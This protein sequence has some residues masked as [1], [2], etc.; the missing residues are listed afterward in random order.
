MKYFFLALL[1]AVSV[2]FGDIPGTTPIGAPIAPFAT[3]ANLGSHTPRYGYGGTLTGGALAQA[4]DLNWYPAVRRHPGQLFCDTNNLVV[5]QLA[6]DLATWQVLETALVFTNVSSL[7]AFDPSRTKPNTT[8]VTLGRNAAGD[9][10]AAGYYY[11]A[12]SAVTTNRGTAFACAAAGR[13]LWNQVGLANIRM[14]GAVNSASTDNYA[15]IQDSIDVLNYAY[16]GT[17]NFGIATAPVLAGSDRIIGD[18]FRFSVLTMLTRNMPA[19]IA[20]G[21]A[22]TIQGIRVRQA[23][24]ATTAETNSFGLNLGTSFRFSYVKDFYVDGFYNNINTTNTSNFGWFQNNFTDVSLLDFANSAAVLGGSGGGTQNVLENWYIKGNTANQT[25]TVTSASNVGTEIT[26]DFTGPSDIE[27]GQYVVLSGVTPSGYNAGFFV[28][29][30][31][32]TTITGTLNSDPGSYVSGGTLTTYWTGADK[33][34]SVVDIRFIDYRC[35]VMNIEWVKAPHAFTHLNTKGDIFGL[36]MEGMVVTDASDPY[37]IGDRFRPSSIK[38]WEYHN[39]FVRP[40]VNQYV[41]KTSSAFPTEPM[42]MD[43]AIG[44]FRDLYIPTNSTLALASLGS[45]LNHS[46]TTDNNRIVTTLRAGAIPVIT[47]SLNSQILRAWGESNNVPPPFRT[48]NLDSVVQSR[49]L[50][51]GISLSEFPG[52]TD[53]YVVSTMGTPDLDTNYFT[54][55]V[56]VDVP[57]Q[58]PALAQAGQSIGIWTLGSSATGLH[59]AIAN[60]WNLTLLSSGSLQLAYRDSSVTSISGSYANFLDRFGGRRVTITAVRGPDSTVLYAD[61]SDLGISGAIATLPSTNQV[62][63]TYFVLGG[64]RTTADLHWNNFQRATIWRKALTRSELIQ[65]IDLPSVNREIASDYQLP[66]GDFETAGAPFGSWSTFT[67]GL[68]TI[69]RTNDA[70]HG[71]YSAVV[72]VGTGVG[73]GQIFQSSITIPGKSY[74]CFFAAKKSTSTN[75]GVLFGNQTTVNAYYDPGS[76]ILTTNWQ[77]FTFDFVASNTRFTTGRSGSSSADS[78][79]QIDDIILYELQPWMDLVPQAGNGTGMIDQSGSGRPGVLSGVSGW[80]KYQPMQYSFSADQ[81]NASVTVLYYFPY[82]VR[83]STVLTANRTI[84][85][86]TT[87]MYPGQRFQIVRSGLGAFTLDVGGLYTIGAST[88]ATVEVKFNGTAMELVSVARQS[89][90]LSLANQSLA[91]ASITSLLTGTATAT[92]TGAAVG[93]LVVANPRT[94]LTVGLEVDFSRV[95]AAN[96]VEITL[97]NRTLGALGTTNNWDILVIKP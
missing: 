30:I 39:S 50:N 45:V 75:C 63:G 26:V 80:L 44:Q 83:F 62:I 87:G 5:Y 31:T 43:L 21:F 6:S 91:Y 7:V 16:L 41:I 48:W 27:R 42:V 59:S 1:F 19:L 28:T 10:G 15:A 14:F 9:G 97:G 90:G 2:V 32:G 57:Y 78:T 33:T 92:V 8:F 81:G 11:D 69:D 12:S 73:S 88:A 13:I 4:Q 94:A 18:G 54:V 66:N 79:L 71:S 53:G 56:T 95:S 64:R 82:E 74:R 24:P 23:T 36:H 58:L 51:S 35:N 84:T 20:D 67:S 70:Y 3:N 25:Y 89:P 17:G 46:I 72:Y 37:M 52:A 60:S 77:T 47:N 38:G 61:G 29:S 86:T 34:G 96:T 85:F 40:G 22:N 55:S 49:V 65:A 68:T 76:T 93:D